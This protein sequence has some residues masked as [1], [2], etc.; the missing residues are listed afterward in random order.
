M[1]DESGRFAE[2]Y[3]DVNVQDLL[4]SK[5]LVPLENFEEG[6]PEITKCLLMDSIISLAT[7]YHDIPANEMEE[8]K[9]LMETEPE[10]HRT[11]FPFGKKV[12][13]EMAGF[14]NSFLIRYPD[15]GDTMRLYAAKTGSGGH[16]NDAMAAILTYLDIPGITG[17][18]IL[19]LIRLSYELWNI[20]HNHILLHYNG[21]DAS[22][23]M[24]LSVPV[25]TAVAH[26]ASPE[27]AQNAMQIGAT[28]LGLLGCTRYA[29]AGGV[30]NMKNAACGC[31]VYK[32]LWA[33][34]MSSLIQTTPATFT[35]PMGFYENV[36]PYE[37]EFTGIS[38]M[39]VYG[40]LEL[41]VWP[42]YNVAQ[43]PVDCAAELHAQVGDKL[44]HITHITIK[45][46]QKDIIKIAQKM[47]NRYPHNHATADHSPYWGVAMALKYGCVGLHHFEEKYYKDPDI[48]R[49]LGISDCEVFT[50]EDTEA[51]GIG[52]SVSA[53]RVTVT[54]D[55]GTEYSTLYK[56]HGGAFDGLSLTER[57]A[58]MHKIV[59]TKQKL[60]EEAFGYDLSGVAKVVYDM[61]NQTGEALLTALHEALKI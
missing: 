8:L 20:F 44:D 51:E 11:A 39:E 14:I 55:D 29:G 30:R 61:E 40:P 45:K 57:A 6:S 49:L 16:P 28:L 35:A 32:A 38:D 15:W 21:W 37:G 13:F 1:G 2:Q 26:D 4:G 58:A 50:A 41:K 12:S 10:N 47:E 27:Q 5:I 31:Q 23:V 9:K 25:M 7:G 18:K 22:S 34:R 48:V 17:K 59:N 46:T 3:K 53:T 24:C 43:A 60:I 56:Q 42:M 36:A 33:Y 52:N 54:M 19:E